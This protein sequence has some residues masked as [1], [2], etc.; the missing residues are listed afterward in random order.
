MPKHDLYCNLQCRISIGPNA[1]LVIRG[2]MLNLNWKFPIGYLNWKYFNHWFIIQNI[3]PI[4]IIHLKESIS[5]TWTTITL[6]WLYSHCTQRHGLLHGVSTLLWSWL[7]SSSRRFN[8][9]SLCFKA[10]VNLLQLSETL[11]FSTSCNKV[12]LIW[13]ICL[14]SALAMQLTTQLWLY[15]ADYS[16]PI[17][18]CYYLHI[19]LQHQ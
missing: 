6:F 3:V 7:S 11:W 4:I 18:L 1:A 12:Y 15:M 8:S 16:T 10:M 14:G 2:K 19:H 9:A 13:G 17:G 5:S